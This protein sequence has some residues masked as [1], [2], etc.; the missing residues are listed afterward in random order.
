MGDPSKNPTLIHALREWWRQNVAEEGAGATVRSLCQELWGF[1]RDSTPEQRR[2]RYGDIEFD[3][4]H[5]VDTTSATVGWRNR[6]LGVFHSPYQPTDPSLFHEILGALDLD[7]TDYTFIDIGSGKG[8]SLLMA[9]DYPFRKVMG[10]E[11]LPELDRIARE[12]I[13]KYKSEKQECF[14]IESCCVDAR[15]FC[16]PTDP[17]LLYLFNPLPRA[18]LSQLLENLEHSLL[19]H[20]RKVYLAYHNPIHADLLSSCSWIK[21]IGGT[22]QFHVYETGCPAGQNER[23]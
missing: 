22:H 18:G 1:L 9:S 3:W 17:T 13:A 21:Q 23:V 2:R 5:R 6:L 19:Q 20:P 11:L 15:S 14:Q 4:H 12:N 7:F 16:F 8:R 10:V